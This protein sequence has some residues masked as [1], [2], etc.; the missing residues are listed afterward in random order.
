[1]QLPD[2][3]VS[4]DTTIHTGDVHQT[5][6]VPEGPSPLGWFNL[7]LVVIAIILAVTSMLTDAWLVDHSEDEVLGFT[8]V[9]DIQVGL[10][11]MSVTAC[12]D[13]DC[14]TSES[15]IGDEHDD[16]KKSL[17]ELEVDSDDEAWDSCNELG[18]LATA[19]LTGII[20]ISLG[21]VALLG[22]GA[23]LVMSQL[24]H[25]FPFSK[26]SPL[27]GG[28][29]GLGGVLVWWVLHPDIGDVEL[30]LGWIAWVAITSGA[31]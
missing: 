16:C 12:I 10:D 8:I 6:V 25:L 5:T 22:A 7:G 11:D 27:A 29:L 28:V 1:M 3:V 24:G 4:G 2:S 9:S 21:V 15:D 13:G 31:L 18:Q 30:K 23:L 14:E 19:G 26:L 20:L 17:E